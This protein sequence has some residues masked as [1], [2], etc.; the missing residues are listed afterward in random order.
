[1]EANSLLLVASVTSLGVMVNAVEFWA[2]TML[3]AESAKATVTERIL[4]WQCDVSLG[5]W[6]LLLLTVISKNGVGVRECVWLL[7]KSSVV[8]VV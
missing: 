4:T 2:A 5:M 6:L 8:V 3:S 7:D 1:M